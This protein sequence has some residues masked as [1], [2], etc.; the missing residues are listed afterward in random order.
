MYERQRGLM[1]LPIGGMI[2]FVGG[3]SPAAVIE[4]LGI[5][6]EAGM[7]QE[8]SAYCGRVLLAIEI[9]ERSEKKEPSPAQIAM[10]PKDC[11][12]LWS[13]P[14]RRTAKTN[15]STSQR[16]AMLVPR[17]VSRRRANAMYDCA[18]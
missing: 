7:Y 11:I 12:D 4:Q 9:E 8:A 15:K 1:D 5:P 16:L 3:R 13:A 14:A 17:R 10:K 2:P 6:R 18:C